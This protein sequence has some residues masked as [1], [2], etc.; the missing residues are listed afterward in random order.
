MAAPLRLPAMLRRRVERM[1][2]RLLSPP[3]SPPVDFAA[4]AGAPALVAADSVSWRVFAN[5]VTLFIGGVAAVLLELAEPRV[6]HGVWD[7][8]GFR[9][10]PLKRL[11]RTGLAAMVTVYA[12]ADQARA[13]IDNVSRMHGRIAGTTAA[14][15]PYRALDP[16]LLI[17]V[18]ATAAWGFL[19]AQRAYAR[20]LPQA[21]SDR[22]WAENRPVARLYGAEGAPGSEAEWSQLMAGMQPRL[23]PSPVIAEFLAIMGRVPALPLLA[24][25]VQRLML[26]GAVAILPPAIAA[27]IGL[28]A[29][30]WRLSPRGRRLVRALAGAADRLAIR[31][32]PAVQACRRLGLPDDHLYRA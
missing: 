26:K 3:G 31:T 1:A 4:P 27:Q 8:S 6:R 15:A 7:H 23:E 30:R 21:E 20:P 11:Q 5:P 16:D 24:R 32:W 10:Q 29:R 13:M 25:P 14:G 22:Y 9:D 17:W 19:E 2:E 12:A 28:D 18:Q